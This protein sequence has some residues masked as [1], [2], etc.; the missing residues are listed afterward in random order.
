MIL[1]NLHT[2][3]AFHWDWRIKLV[4][5]DD[6]KPDKYLKFFILFPLRHGMSKKIHLNLIFNLQIKSKFFFSPQFFSCNS[7]TYF[8]LFFW[9]EVTKQNGINHN[10]K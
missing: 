8:A 6:N 3:L 10:N 2:L 5:D 7:Q 1:N 9:L 4:F